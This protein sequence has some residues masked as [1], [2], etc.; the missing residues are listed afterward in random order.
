M[1]SFKYINQ[2]FEEN[3]KTYKYVGNDKSLFYKYLLSPL[4]DLCVKYLIPEWLA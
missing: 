1:F 2:D 4:G 3:L